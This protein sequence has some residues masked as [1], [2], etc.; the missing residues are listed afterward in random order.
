MANGS[1]LGLA[2]GTPSNTESHLLNVM[3][4]SDPAKTNVFVTRFDLPVS[5]NAVVLASGIAYVA[6][7][8]AGLQVINY[9]AF[10][11]QGQPPQVNISSP[12]ADVDPDTP[13]VQV[14]EGTSIPIFAD[15]TDD[16]QTANVELLVDGEVV[17]N[18][19]SFPFELTA[20]ALGE[21]PAP[22]AIEVRAKANDTGGN[23]A[24]SNILVFELV[25]DTIAPT[26]VGTS[27]GNGQALGGGLRAARV[28]FSEPMAADTMTPA[29]FR[30]RRLQGELVAPV[31]VKLR[32][33]DRFLQLTYAA[34]PPGTYELVIASSQVTDRAGNPLGTEDRVIRFILVPEV[35]YFGYNPNNGG[36]LELVGW[37]NGT[38]YEI[39][40]LDNRSTFKSGTLG[41]FG[42]A[43]VPMEEVR[44]FKL[45]SNAPLL[46]I[47]GADSFSQGANY[48]YPALDGRLM[49]GREFIIRTPVLAG[50]NEIII[51]AY[52]NSII[53]LRDT[54]RAIATTQT[55][56]AG[57]FYATTRAPLDPFT[58]YS[59]ESSGRI[60]IMSN[61]QNGNTSV[62]SGNGTDVGTVFLLGTHGWERG[63]VAIFAYEDATVTGINIESGTEAFARTLVS[64]EFAY[65]GGLGSNKFRLISTGKIGVWAGDTEA[66]DSIRWMGDDLTMNVG[67][68]GR[69]IL[70]HT[71]SFGAF[72]FAY[73]DG[74]TVDIDGEVTV[75]DAEQ[76]ID[77]LP[78]A[79][80]RIGSD[81]P[82][83]V[84]TIGGNFLNDWDAILR[85]VPADE[86]GVAPTVF[87][88]SPTPGE[89]FVE[90]ASVPIRVAAAD[91]VAVASVEFLV[92][93]QVIARDLSPPYRVDF[94]VPTGPISLTIGARA[95]DLGGN[96][97]VAQTLVVNVIP[98]PLT[99]VVGRVI[100]EQ[101]IV[102][103]AD[104]EVFGLAS[105]SGADGTFAIPDV[106]TVLGDVIV[107]VRGKIDGTVVDGRSSPVAPVP[108][109]VTDVGDVLLEDVIFPIDEGVL[110]RLELNGDLRDSSGNERHATLIGGQFVD[111]ALGTGLHVGPDDPLGIDWSPYAGLLSHPYTVEMVLT[112][113]STSGFKKL[114]SFDDSSDNGWYYS[115][116]GI[117]AYPNPGLGGQAQAGQL[118]Y[119]AFVST[120]PDQV[121]VYF[122][123]ALLGST[124]ASF[125]APPSQAIFF[126]DDSSTGRGERVDA[127]VEAVRISGVSRTAEEIAAIQQ[128][129]EQ[130]SANP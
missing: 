55:I 111:T 89:T 104:V 84:Q 68:A 6:D 105:V 96:V 113:A 2:G 88:A 34:L 64:G 59:V 110:A 53:T 52:E 46:A 94:T 27:P 123:G 57:G 26:I 79:L 51:F 15:V 40:D 12:V 65:I 19:V 4:V 130:L 24:L 36:I 107:F 30:M 66:G 14:I 93:G 86:L 72:V 117:R 43:S 120:A 69:D 31:N 101:G 16:V 13:G 87:I 60:S 63:A 42:T 5:P 67:A 116:G 48:F 91:D 78:D 17:A 118:H 9:L 22:T 71:Q 37:Q 56:P 76:F 70:I 99:I 121:D 102:V 127:V 33:N 38:T 44:H 28:R 32:K 50:N 126:R 61:A 90:G 115:S 75:L 54:A 23:S 73:K 45:R 124:N 95:T 128:R 108:G 106:P 49:I 35:V 3:D 20:L 77:L 85:L 11:N 80:H 8:S 29:N 83:V 81:K 100:D 114:F 119:I 21:V 82:I 58:V 25:P 97:G 10:D 39:V 74:T 103:G 1:G 41:R 98:D 112:P 92:D 129:I 18:D 62:P 47:L 7:G 109:G 122:Q 125:T